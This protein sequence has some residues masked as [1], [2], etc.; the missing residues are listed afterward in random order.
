M[1]NSNKKSA[2]EKSDIEK[3][4]DKIQ[5]QLKKEIAQIKREEAADRAWMKRY[6]W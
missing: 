3:Q 2:K 6:E 1:A 5:K 4:N